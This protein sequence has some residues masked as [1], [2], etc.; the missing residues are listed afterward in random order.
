LAI[1][2]YHSA[3]NS[4][5]GGDASMVRGPST[6]FSPFSWTTSILPHMELGTLYEQLRFDRYLKDSP[7]DALSRTVVGGFICPSDPAGSAPVMHNRCTGPWPA[8]GDVPNAEP[9]FAMGSWYGG[10]S[11]PIRIHSC[12]YACPCGS[13]YPN[14]YCCKASPAGVFGGVSFDE[15]TDGLSN[16]FLAGELL[17]QYTVHSTMLGGAGGTSNVPMD[18]SVSLCGPHVPGGDTNVLHAE[19]PTEYCDGFR[20]VHPGV[21]NFVMC[22][23]SVHS[24]TKFIDYELFNNLATSAGG[25][26]VSLNDL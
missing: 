13:L 9:E 20:S 2:S 25:E 24:L 19:Y 15:V 7:N 14:C 3:R 26:P 18:T 12:P 22:D 4:L 6:K 1:H 11:G 8:A 23:G 16:T 21:V 5:P 10:S 17:P